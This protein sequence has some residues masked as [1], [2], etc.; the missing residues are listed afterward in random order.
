MSGDLLG[1]S[2]KFVS[3]HHGVA[4]LLGVPPVIER[5]GQ[6]LGAMLM[7]VAAKSASDEGCLIT[8]AKLLQRAA[9][10]P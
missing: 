6:A 8:V 2:P 7:A 5:R 3:L 10:G 1:G 9:P 4:A